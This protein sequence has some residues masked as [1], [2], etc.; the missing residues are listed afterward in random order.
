MQGYEMY[1][2][3][4]VVLG[5]MDVVMVNTYRLGQGPPPSAVGLV[6]TPRANGVHPIGGG[7]A[8]RNLPLIVERRSPARITK[9]LLVP[10]K[11]C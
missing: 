9:G 11:N 2:R 1:D 4:V 10:R 8:T 3:G 6:P 7:G 5:E